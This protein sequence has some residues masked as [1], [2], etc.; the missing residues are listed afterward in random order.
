MGPE[1]RVVRTAFFM[2]GFNLHHS[3]REAS[4]AL[5]GAHTRWLDLRSFCA[6]YLADVGGGAKLTA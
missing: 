3:L 1:A 6:S 2:D 4:V 5:G